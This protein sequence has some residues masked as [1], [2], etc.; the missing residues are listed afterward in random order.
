MNFGTRIDE[1]TSIAILD[2]FLDGGGTFLDTANNYNQW[3]GGGDGGESEALIGRWLRSRGVRDEVVVATKVGARTTVPGD[4][5]LRN[6]EGLSP[7][8]IRAAAEGSLRRLGRDR[9][10]LYY[11]HIDDRDTPLEETVAEFAELAAE[12]VAGVLGCSNTATWRLAEARRLAQDRGGAPY[13]CVQQMHTYMYARPAMGA[14]NVVSDELLDYA[15]AHDDLRILCYSPLFAG[16]YA[17]RHR[18]DAPS[19]GSAAA[20]RRLEPPGTAYDHASN[21]HRLDV[22][23]EVAAEVGAT[24]NQIVLAWMLGDESPFI[25]VFSASTTAQV[26]ECLAALDVE[27]DPEL[28]RRLDDA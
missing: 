27:L 4:P 11:A 23:D 26:G 9:L 7:A 13:T 19:P 12:G 15:S 3:L 2:R 22:L 18:T 8:A 25:P 24:P 14:L 6:R 20:W 1:A 28:R 5:D 17:R 21:R 10:D 16:Y